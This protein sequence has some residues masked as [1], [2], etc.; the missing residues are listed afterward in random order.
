MNRMKLIFAAL[1]VASAAAPAF[2]QGE[3]ETQRAAQHATRRG[4]LRPRRGPIQERG[5]QLLERADAW[6]VAV[7]RPDRQAQSPTGP[8]RPAR[9]AVRLRRR[10]GFAR[11][12]RQRRR[13]ALRPLHPAPDRP[14]DQRRRRGPHDR[15]QAPA[16]SGGQREVGRDQRQGHPAE[17]H[18]ARLHHFQAQRGR[19]RRR[20]RDERG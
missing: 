13:R 3:S 19:H 8:A 1:L 2:S 11:P 5:W 18:L 7:P 12:R 20:R 4:D 14:Q 16:D 6:A 17:Q 15:G 10:E 9:R